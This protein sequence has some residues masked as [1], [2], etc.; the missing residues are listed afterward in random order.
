MPEKSSAPID[1]L[2]DISNPRRQCQNLKHPLQDILVL[3]FC[4]VVAGRD[5]FVEMAAWARLHEDFFRTFLELPNG[6][7]AHDTF[8]RVLAM[9]HAPT[10]QGILLA[11]CTSVVDGAAN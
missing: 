6:T 2:Q 1:R 8:T 10:L 11:G 9:L 7:P 3:G 5:D 4:G